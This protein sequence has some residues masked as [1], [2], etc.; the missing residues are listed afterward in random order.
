[1]QRDT[2]KQY[3]RLR[4][5]LETEREQLTARLSEVTEALA[6]F[7]GAGLPPAASGKRAGR[8]AGR[9][10]VENSLSL[11]EAVLAVIKGKALTKEE[12]L[13][14]IQKLGYQFRTSNPLNSIGTVLYGKQPRFKNV[15]G[16]FSLD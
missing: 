16:K 6:G 9:V 1:M 4:R 13:A 11:K 12:V 7:Q 10:K 3:I 5:A 15:D 14:A 8:P 2:I